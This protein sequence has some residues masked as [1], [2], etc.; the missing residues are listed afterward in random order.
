MNFGSRGVIHNKSMRK[1]IQENPQMLGN[2]LI[3]QKNEHISTIVHEFAH[4]TAGS[5]AFTKRAKLKS[6]AFWK[7]AQSIYS[8]YRSEVSS[9]VK[10]GDNKKLE[11]YILEVT[12]VQNLM[13]L[14][15][16][17]LLNIN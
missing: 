2:V 17:H 16:R 10:L 13:S 7:E 12:P 4:L 1:K 9:L 8:D 6:R 11:V 5:S 14:W 3:D 15:Q